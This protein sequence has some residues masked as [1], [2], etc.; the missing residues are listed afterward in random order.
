MYLYNKFTFSFVLKACVGLLDL[1]KGKE[2]HSVVKQLGFEKD[3]SVSNAL[4]DMDGKYGCVLYAPK[5]FDRIV[6]RDVGSWPQW[7]VVIV[8]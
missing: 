1:N 4:T 3:A 5:V 6:K 7:F 2:V 8:M